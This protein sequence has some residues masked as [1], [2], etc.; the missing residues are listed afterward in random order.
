MNEELY[1]LEMNNTW[2]VTDLP[3]HEKAI[4]CKWLYKTK[5][6]ADGSIDKW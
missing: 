3:P 4:G 6:N 1:T 5:F 2:E